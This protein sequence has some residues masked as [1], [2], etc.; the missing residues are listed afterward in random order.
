MAETID[1]LD[2][3]SRGRFDEIIDVRSPAE[4]A[5]DHIPGAVNLPV[6]S[7]AERAAVGMIYV[8]DS[9]FRARRIGAALVAR[10]IAGHL[11]G[12]LKERPGGW[13]PL[14]YCWRGGQRSAAMATVLEQVGWRVAL[15][16]GGYRTWRRRVT[17]ALY[18]AE[19]AFEVVLIDGF[20]GVAKTEILGRVAA[21]GVQAIDLEG[22]AGHRGSLLGAVPGHPQPSQKMFESWLL[23][24]LEALDP[25]RPTLVEAESSKIGD[26][27]VPPTVWK[28][29]A[30]APR[31][32]LRAPA[33]A[34]AS[35]LTGAY[36]D[37]ASD[38]E[39]LKATLSRLPGRHG[40]KRLEA[41][42]ELARTGK[43][44]ALAAALMETHYDPAYERSSRIDVRPS[45][46]TIDMETLDA[47]EQE[48]AARAVADLLR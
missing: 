31:I 5:L 16:A 46:G 15:V 40:R 11:E 43:L 24:A 27:M 22:L 35:Y 42:L 38:L 47:A 44:E 6:L 48:R 20:T 19:P 8:Q 36:A 9:R 13:A 25:T 7:D 34:R 23:A 41:W 26:R 10:N 3:V 32:E 39:A 1:R 17:A 4:F 2:A 12:A 37:I 45:L 30:R 21:L 28:A 33:G 14:I 29:M 18:D